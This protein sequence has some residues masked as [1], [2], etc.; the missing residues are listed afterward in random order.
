M[1]PERFARWLIDCLLRNCLHRNQMGPFTIKGK[2]Y[3][4]CRD[5]T[6]VI[7]WSL[8]GPELPPPH[9]TQL[10]ANQYDVMFLRDLKME[11]KP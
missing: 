4:V 3:R 5:C 9:L 6:L 7:P 10:G 1:I 2:S 11:G 8:V